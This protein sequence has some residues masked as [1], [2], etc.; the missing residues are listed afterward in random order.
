MKNILIKASIIILFIFFLQG[1]CY[2]LTLENFNIEIDKKI[3]HPGEKVTLKVDFGRKLNE[4]E[5]NVAYDKNLFQYY[6]ANKDINLYDN[7]DVVTITYPTMSTKEPVEEIEIIFKAN[8]DIISSNPTNFKITLQNMKDE[9]TKEAIDNPLLPIEEVVLLEPVYEAYEF[10]LEY[11]KPLLA[12]RENDIKL[13]LKSDMGQIYSNTKIYANVVSDTESEV[14]FNAID[15][16]GINHNILEDGWGGENGESIGGLNVMKELSLNSKFSDPG[17][18]KITFELR[19]LNN[20]DFVISS[21]TFNVIVD[22]E[23]YINSIVDNQIENSITAIQEKMNF[24]NNVDKGTINRVEN[25]SNE[26]EYKP[27]TLPKAGSTI[28]FLIL[29]IGGILILI[30]CILKKKDDEL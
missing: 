25:N 17:K 19:D 15:S 2:A 26:I 27:T 16:V 23:N 14:Q 13:I 24:E 18:Y 3:V 9:L 20:P 11:N 1:N 5:I 28:Y 4:F 21:Q 7:G 8:Q 22:E 12:N 10:E 29:P 6:S 30:Y